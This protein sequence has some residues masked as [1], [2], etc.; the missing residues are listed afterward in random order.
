MTKHNI[1]RTPVMNFLK[2]MNLKTRITISTVLLIAFFLIITAVAGCVVISDSSNRHITEAAQANVNDFAARIEA[3]IE[4]EEQ[5]VSDIADNIGYEGYDTERREEMFDFLVSKA[6]A[7]PEIY[8]LY[9]GC[10]DNY[11]S[12]SDGWIPDEDYIITDRQWYIDAAKA[13]GTIVTDP[14][15]DAS[16]GKMVVTIARAVRDESGAVTSVVAADMFL[17]ELQEITAQ[18]VYTESGYPALIS[19][20]GSVIIHKNE[21]YIPT[22]DADE[23]EI[24]V[25]YETTFSD[26]TSEE[27]AGDLV[28]YT[29]KDYDGKEKLVITANIPAPDWTF[30]FAMETSEMYSDVSSLIL[31]FCIMIPVIILISALLTILVVN[32]SFKPLGEV[33]DA[34]ERMIHGDLSV[35]FDYKA[36][37][38]IGRVCRIIEDTN[39]VLKSYVDDIS[40]HLGEMADGDF[41]RTVNLEYVGDFASIKTSLNEIL[42]SLGSAFGNIGKATDAVFGGAG[43]VSDGANSLAESVSIQTALIDE[44]VT[45]V[46][47]AGQKIH[48]NVKLTDNAKVISDKTAEDVEHSNEQMRS[49][50][51]AMNE[52]R[53]TSDE[54]QKINK[55]IEGIAF[56]TNILALNASVEAARAGDAGK[57]FAVVADEV[58]NLAG[59]SAEASSQTTLLIQNSSEAVEKGMRYAQQ[60]AESMGKVVEQTREVDEIIMNIAASSHEQDAY[61]SEI[62]EKASA[63]SGHVTSSAA[64]AEESASASVELN[65]Q[66]S[67]LKQLMEKFRV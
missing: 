33:A 54:I 11:S 18:C 6:S 12:F 47:A 35:T 14:Y 49:L 19:S 42:V 38:E 16:T 45:A 22:V 40:Q 57:G 25:Q 41:S 60:T 55:T 51:E 1:E 24:T 30:A 9:V 56:Q 32:H 53:H 44:I 58:R 17:D 36:N 67:I 5:K 3:W 62:S 43:N 27:A 48:E 31:I 7:L 46:T 26:K 28:S 59:K 61:I 34:A 15:V 66:A 64:N 63:V 37:D 65:S 23:N 4:L 20:V 13:D 21:A 2:K 10:P 50:L 8:A 29:C 39:R 52:I